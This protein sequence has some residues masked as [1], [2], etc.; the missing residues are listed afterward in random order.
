MPTYVD[1]HDAPG[2]SPEDVAAAHNRDVAIQAKY[3]VHYHTYWFDPDEGTVF[4]LVEGPSKQAVEDVH[5]EAHGLLASSIVEVG[6]TTSLND[7]MG[8]APA[9]QVGTPYVAPAMRAIVFTDICGSVAQ[10][11]LLG[12]DGHMALLTAH[13]RIVREALAAH[14]GR[15]VK[16]TGDGIMAA[17]TSVTAAVAFAVD[18]QRHLSERNQTADV[19]FDVSIGISAGEPITDDHEDLFGAAVQ[20]AARLCAAAPAGGIVTSVAVKELCIGKPFR[21]E[22]SASL[23]LKGIDEPTPSHAVAWS[24]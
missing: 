8:T 20:L 14:D 19:P 10:T 4:C 16:H 6:S 7:I 11:Q 13:D 12:D 21:F 22:A 23:A 3:G 18:V 1:R 9:Y 5:R 24:D 15:E 17:F 2:V